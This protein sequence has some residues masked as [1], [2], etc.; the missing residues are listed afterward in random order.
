MA[1]KNGEKVLAAERWNFYFAPCE[2]VSIAGHT[3]K[4]PG[5]HAI[6]SVAEDTANESV[7]FTGFKAQFDLLPG[8]LKKLED[9][10]LAERHGRTWK[11]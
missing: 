9:A 11:S 4:L 6:V 2:A 1:E 10:G 3:V 8:Q 7:Y 5:G